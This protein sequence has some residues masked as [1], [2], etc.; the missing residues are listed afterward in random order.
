MDVGDESAPRW[1]EGVSADGL[2]PAH[3]LV[4]RRPFVRTVKTRSSRVCLALAAGAL[5]ASTLSAAATAWA[6]TRHVAVAVVRSHNR[7][8]TKSGSGGSSPVLT[9]PAPGQVSVWGGSAGVPPVVTPTAVENLSNVVAVDAGNNSDY[10]LESNGTVWAWGSGQQGAL[11]DGNDNSSYGKAV[12]VQFPSGVDVRSIGEAAYSGMAVDSTGQGWQWG[13]RHC[14]GESGNTSVPTK[15][16]GV[17]DAVAVQGAGH[18]VHWLLSNGTVASCGTGQGGQLGLGPVKHAAVPIVIPG[19]SHIVSISAGNNAVA[20][21]DSSGNVYAWGANANGQVGVGSATDI[22]V[23]TKVDLPAPVTEI[24]S[25]GDVL[26]NGHMLA[27]LSTG[28]VYGWGTDTSGQLGDGLHSDERSPVQVPVPS[29]VTFTSVIAAGR[30]SLGLDSTGK[31]WAWGG[32]A[33]GNGSR[34]GSMVPVAID[35]DVVQISGTA[36]TAVDLHS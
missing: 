10:A 16:V 21:L 35:I 11:G 9:P 13:Q 2:V 36:A 3:G 26:K 14:K 32:G 24:S 15:V 20:A 23:P 17:S 34:S 4:L 33:I 8:R 28:Q 7:T 25:G 29:G 12:Q 18:H 19:L 31:V 5:G 30:F 6:G 22:L 27:L 1:L